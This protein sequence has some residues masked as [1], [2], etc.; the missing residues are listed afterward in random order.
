MPTIKKGKKKSKLKSKRERLRQRWQDWRQA[1]A[2]I[3]NDPAFKEFLSTIFSQIAAPGSI[4][5][6]PQGVS[7]MG[8]LHSSLVVNAFRVLAHYQTDHSPALITKWINDQEKLCIYIVSDAELISR[9]DVAIG[10]D[11]LKLVGTKEIVH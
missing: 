9:M 5:V 8:S 7:P 10:P 4:G 3:N 11:M 2:R 1:Q 6:T